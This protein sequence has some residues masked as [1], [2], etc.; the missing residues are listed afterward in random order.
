MNRFRLPALALLAL[1]LLITSACKKETESIQPDKPDTTP[2]FVGK[3]LVLIS[4][5]ISPAVDV[6]GDGKVDSDLLVFLRPCERDNTII[7]EKNGTMSGGNGKLSCTDGQADPSSVSASTWSYTEQT[8]TL[9]I[10]SSADATD[11]SDWKVLEASST[12]LKVEVQDDDNSN[13]QP[14][15]AIMTW[16]AL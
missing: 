14:S 10:T 12:G 9:R 15:K 7:F 4:F 2:P 6:D 13:G 5:Q 16:K 11:V 1:F 3:S 8:K